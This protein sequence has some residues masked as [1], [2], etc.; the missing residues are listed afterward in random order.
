MH[1]ELATQQLRCWNSCPNDFFKTSKPASVAFVSQHFV[2]RPGFW[3][4]VGHAM[5]PTIVSHHP[6][7]QWVT[8]F[9][10]A[11]NLRLGCILCCTQQFSQRTVCSFNGTHGGVAVNR[12]TLQQGALLATRMYLAEHENQLLPFGQQDPKRPR[13]IARGAQLRLGQRE[14]LLSRDS[15]ARPC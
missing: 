9:Q 6:A 4:H 12:R 5:D 14:R 15:L 10:S 3:S 1:F 8:R 2:R 11:S 13:R 7:N